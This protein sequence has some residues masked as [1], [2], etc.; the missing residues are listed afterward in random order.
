MKVYALVGASGSGKSHR[1]GLIANELRIPV[2]LDDGLL[3]YDGKILAGKSAKRED[4]KMAAIR[5]ALF[6]DDEQV[7]DV[8]KALEDIDADKILL[9][10]T[11]IGMVERIN[12]KL[13][14]N[15][16]DEYLDIK[17]FASEEEIKKAMSVRKNEG[18][19]VIPVPTIEVQPEFPGYLLHSLEFFFKKG[20]KTIKQEKSIVRPKF[21]FYGNLIIFNKVLVEIVEYFLKR[22]ESISDFKKLKIDDNDNDLT[23]NICL[24]LQY[25]VLLSEVVKN[26]QHQLKKEVEKLT[27]LTVK[28]IN[29]EVYS[30]SVEE[31]YKDD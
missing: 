27:G 29:I 21:S 7:K 15:G 19:H 1:A 3:I 13:E 16:I 8:K 30:L 20:N 11:S 22:E 17:D 6:Y 25:G 24:E 26:I 14:L 9:L 5:R 2:I 28:K 31:R 4:S 10:G 23:I 12:E 18:K